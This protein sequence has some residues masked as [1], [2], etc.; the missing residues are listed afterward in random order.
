MMATCKFEFDYFSLGLPVPALP[1]PGQV[2]LE[3]APGMRGVDGKK[4]GKVRG[5]LSRQ[6]PHR[7]QRRQSRASLYTDVYHIDRGA[8]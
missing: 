6:A 4:R 5:H 3:A 2:E 1:P 7:E 8:L